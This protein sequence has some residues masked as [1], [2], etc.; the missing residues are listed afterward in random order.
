M[1][2]ENNST[3]RTSRIE[4]L[5]A[6]MATRLFHVER[7]RWCVSPSDVEG[8][9]RLL[10]EAAD[11]FLELKAARVPISGRRPS[12]S[13]P[14]LRVILP[15]IEHEIGAGR[16]FGLTQS[17]R[18]FRLAVKER[19]AALRAENKEDDLA[20]DQAAISVRRTIH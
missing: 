9:Q 10:D 13:T 5:R 15:V 8:R 18:A 7:P 3:A 19:Q 11:L 2:A 17:Q 20:D 16:C 4:A 14:V 12:L 1:T 6:R